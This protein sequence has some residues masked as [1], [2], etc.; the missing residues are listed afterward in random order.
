MQM[1]V[2][3]MAKLVRLEAERRQYIKAKNGLYRGR[4]RAEKARSLDQRRR[5]LSAWGWEA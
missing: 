1:T 4:A 3:N 5:E 2:R